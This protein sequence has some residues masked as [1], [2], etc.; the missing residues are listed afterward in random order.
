MMPRKIELVF[1][2]PRIFEVIQAV[3]EDSV[4][5][6][7]EFELIKLASLMSVGGNLNK[8]QVVFISGQLIE[9]F[10]NESIAD[11]KICFERGAIGLYG[12]IQRM[13]G[14]TIGVWMKKYLDEKYEVLEDKLKNEKDTPW[15]LPAEIPK[16]KDLTKEQNED[17][18]RIWQEG[19]DKWKANVDSK[20]QKRSFVLSETE[21]L[22]KVKQLEKREHPITSRAEL[23]KRERHFEWIKANF[24]ARTGEKL[25]TWISEED[26]NASN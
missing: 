9:Q 26:F 12:D 11:F 10:P 23:I 22:K 1:D 15:Q 13:D 5:A 4:R 20:D 3:G 19:L 21:T 8:A 6:Q 24:D 2:E 18:Q 25:P 7:I 16:S 14:I 17:R